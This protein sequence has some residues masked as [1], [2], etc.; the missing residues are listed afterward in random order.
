MN[1]QPSVRVDHTGS[2]PLVI[3]EA[4]PGPGAERVRAEV[5]A[6]RAAQHPGVVTL[7]DSTDDEHGAVLR[8]RFCGSRTMANAGR[9]D[10]ER[11]AGL[12]AALATTVADLHDLGVHHGR[13]TPDHVLISADGR[14]VLCGFAEAR[15]GA[16]RA[17]M[18]TDVAALGGLLRDLLSPLDDIAPIPVARIGRRSSWPGYQRRALLNLADQ[19]SADDPFIR[20]TARQFANNLRA[21][22]PGATLAANDGAPGGAFTEMPYDTSEDPPPS[23]WRALGG[24]AFGRGVNRSAVLGLSSAAL[25]V[26]ATISVTLAMPGDGLTSADLHTQPQTAGGGLTPSADPPP[27]TSTAPHLTTTTSEP[28]EDQTDSASPS[29]SA[30]PQSTP[31]SGLDRAAGCSAT[32]GSVVATLAS[33]AECPTA[34]SL[35]G[36]VL[37]VGDSMFRVEVADAAVA[38]GDFACTNSVQ[39]AI[40]DRQ[41]GD[42]FVFDRWAEDD[43]P[44][45][46]TVFQNI[47]GASR[48][49]AETHTTS[50]CHRL[51]VLDNFGIRHV[52]DPN[53]TEETP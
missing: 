43:S 33:G 29:T 36:G 7:V 52:I 39:A 14:P 20:P 51:V 25:I 32:T 41:T 1:D 27:P 15:M 5:A 47:E 53:L 40:I 24:T 34:L 4:L 45:T 3:K 9:L 37:T 44:T 26:V 48:V 10:I 11:A 23:R 31:S 17:E 50:S 49:L 30:P 21:T 13:I 42:L 16:S 19:A 38:V 22:V 6:L 18:A 35:D 8:T 12:V 46:A 2:R 28:I